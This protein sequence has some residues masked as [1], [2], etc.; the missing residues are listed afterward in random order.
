M[1]PCAISGVS[2]WLR[3]SSNNMK[4]VGE[5]V[6]P[7]HRPLEARTKGVECPFMSREK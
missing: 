7:C 4:R 1:T 5:K 6:S 3:T 2:D